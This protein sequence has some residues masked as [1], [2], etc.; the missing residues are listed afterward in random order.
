MLADFIN[1]ELY[2]DNNDGI[3]DKYKIKWSWIPKQKAKILYQN[4]EVRH[5]ETNIIMYVI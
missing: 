4:Y 2:K 3:V 5:F 1:I